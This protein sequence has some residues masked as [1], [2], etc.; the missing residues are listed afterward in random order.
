M[1]IF[2]I[3]GVGKKV[4]PKVNFITVDGERLD[5]NIP[6][7]SII[8]TYDNL[9]YERII[10]LFPAKYQQ[11]LCS[12]DRLDYIN[13]DL[14]LLKNNETLC[15]SFVNN[16]FKYG[17]TYIVKFLGDLDNDLK[18]VKFKEI[19]LNSKIKILTKISKITLKKIIDRQ[20]RK[21]PGLSSYKL[22]ELKSIF[23]EGIDLENLKKCYRKIIKYV[24]FEVI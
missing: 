19:K 17:K 15:Y 21:L 14:I 23:L 13:K 8:R 24:Y 5:S 9:H 3:N 10:N 4:N 18:K 7:F 22:T 2:Y 11:R 16:K 12:I 20:I 6:E 1:V